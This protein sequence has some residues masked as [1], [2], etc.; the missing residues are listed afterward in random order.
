MQNFSDESFTIQPF[1]LGAEFPKKEDRT[2]EAHCTIL[3]SGGKLVAGQPQ[4]ATVLLTDECTFPVS[5]EL[6]LMD[7]AGDTVTSVKTSASGMG[8]ISFIPQIGK[9]YHLNG[10]IDGVDYSFPV[11]DMAS[12]VKV[13]GILNRQRLNYQV[14]EGGEDLTLYR[15]FTYDRLNGLMELPTVN[16]NGIIVL[17][18]IPR[19]LTLFLTDR[20][21]NILSEYTVASHA[22][23]S[24]ILM[25]PDSLS[26]GQ[27][28]AFS[29]PG[30]SEDS[31]V[32]VRV[33]P[34][35]DLLATHA[36]D[37]LHFQT[38]YRS[39]LPFPHHL[40]AAGAK[41]GYADL[42]AWLS[43]A[44]FK[45]FDLKEAVVKDSALYVYLPEQVM[46]FS[47]Q[48]E[49]TNKTPFG[50]GGLVA[51]H[52]DTDWVY[53]AELHGNGRFQMAVDDFMEGETFFLQAINSKGKPNFAN[54]RLD[55]ETYP[56]L[57]N[58]NRFVVP[59]SRYARTEV[60]I[61]GD[62][63]LDYVTDKDNVRN[64]K[65][66]N[67]V[68]KA[69]VRTEA[70]KP[71]HEF[72]STNYAD[73]E[74]IEERAYNTLLDILRDMPGIR[75]EQVMG[76]AYEDLS[77][78][79]QGI[80]VPTTSGGGSVNGNISSRGGGGGVTARTVLSWVISSS[81]GSSTFRQNPDGMPILVDGVRFVKNDYGHI[82]H[83]PAHEIE[84]AQVLRAW[85]TLA[86]TF[87]AIDGTILVKTRSS[88]TRY[89]PPSKGAFYTPTGVS[90]LSDSF[91]PKPW[92]AE[93]PGRYRLLV[94]VFTEKGVQ[95]YEHLFE[96]VEPSLDGQ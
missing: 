10:R 92:K 82:L 27:E 8:M 14:L 43:T 76:P 35:D 25:A 79:M 73:R 72:Y 37:V 54:Y 89:E 46:S 30:Q 77:G 67:V 80:G 86:Y 68:V 34:E 94:D 63:S 53:E 93:K 56:A 75:V 83:M 38:D 16:E 60:V 19:A 88:V 49:K 22:V 57:S 21:V 11:P 40:H 45:R 62:L 61:D 59:K 42:Q 64:Y 84:S 13:Q 96:V 24:E 23:A 66:P 29:F 85:Q 47:G 1:L 65:M 44:R 39:A 41:E 95:S 28:M 48:I 32:I 12:G 91:V 71:T 17:E 51:Y 3:P 70:P 6:H 78:N 9:K 55:D 31:R 33:F 7:E 90:K 74:E 58:H 26:V 2:Y 81:R 20:D 69:N 4:T 18:Q 5:A 52:T 50:K 15:L 36:E 87:G